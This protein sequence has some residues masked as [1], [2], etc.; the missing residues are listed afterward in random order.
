MSTIFK[1]IIDKEIPAKIIYE[2]DEIL[3]FEDISPVAPIHIIII[4]KIEIRTLNNLEDN[5]ALI[6]GKLILVAK[7]I[8]SQKGIAEDGYRVVFNCNENGGQTVFHIHCH[9]IG[10]RVL[11]WPPG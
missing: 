1:K 6:M 11:D 7:K 8:A 3:A 4:P 2:D 10:G 5:D 9:L